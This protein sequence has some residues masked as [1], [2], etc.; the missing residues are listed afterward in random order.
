[1]GG[2]TQFFAGHPIKIHSNVAI[3]GCCLEICRILRRLEDD[4]GDF[5][6][7]SEISFLK[8]CPNRSIPVQKPKWNGMEW[9]EN[10]W[11]K[12]CRNGM[13]GNDCKISFCPALRSSS[14][15]S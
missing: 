11:K 9:N 7:R 8:I 1:L 10:E 15:P 12:M 13:N 6:A 4:P 14:G 3:D 2:G 5:L